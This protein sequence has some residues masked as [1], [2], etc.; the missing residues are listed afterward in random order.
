MGA[1]DEKLGGLKALLASSS[2]GV[3]VADCFYVLDPENFSTHH[4][5][6]R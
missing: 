5:I 3:F 2:K 6:R 1:I 4:L